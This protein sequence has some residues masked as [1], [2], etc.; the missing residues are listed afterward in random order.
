MRFGCIIKQ[1]KRRDAAC[2]FSSRL[3]FSGTEK[4]PGDEVKTSTLQSLINPPLLKN[5]NF[6]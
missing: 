2:T 4:G 3:P 6:S 5:K 1:S